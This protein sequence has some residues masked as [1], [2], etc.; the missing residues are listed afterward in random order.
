MEEVIITEKYAELVLLA[1]QYFGI[2]PSKIESLKGDGSDRSIYRVYATETPQPPVVGVIHH[3]ISENQDFLLLT[4]KFQETG[5]PVPRIFSV[6][7]RENAY[8]MQDLGPDT[9]ADKVIEWNTEN[10][11]EKILS[12]Y[13]LVLDHLFIMQQELPSTLTEFFQHRI[14]DISVYQADLDYF[15]RD[16]LNRFGFESFLNPSVQ[17][18]LQ[19]VLFEHLADLNVGYFVYRDFQARNIMWFENS[20]WFIDYQSAFLGPRYYDMASLLYGSK[21][22]LDGPTRESLNSY[23]Y[24]LLEPSPT[25]SF[26]KYQAL[27]YLFVVLRRL[28]SLGTYGYLSSE[29]GKTA[30]FDSIHPTLEE[31]VGLF[32]S[33]S[34]LG[35]FVNI[36]DMIKKVKDCWEQYGE[37]FRSRL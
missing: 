14:M 19:L 36:F 33:Q 23:Y 29:K 15:K 2:P 12:A 1:E 18:E 26:E 32:Y 37:D 17:H 11:T 6:N 34:C 24:G 3:N 21:S 13:R 30:F 10:Q 22:G 8:L 9:L 31:L 16:F 25:F 35:S 7:S 4:K 27:F 20:P 28:R 5:L